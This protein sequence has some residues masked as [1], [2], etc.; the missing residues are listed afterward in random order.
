MGRL[1]NSWTFT[2]GPPHPEATRKNVAN[3]IDRNTVF[4]LEYFIGAPQ[5][6]MVDSKESSHRKRSV[7]FGLRIVA[8]ILFNPRQI[9]YM[10]IMGLYSI[11][12]FE[13][14]VV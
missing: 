12:R 10:R 13:K 5:S 6:V 3:K 1:S 14:V 11:D 9:R 4:D 2:F 8:F 7:I